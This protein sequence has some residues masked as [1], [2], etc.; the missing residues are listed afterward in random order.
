MLTLSTASNL[1][2]G[3]DTGSLHNVWKIITKLIYSTL[4]LYGKTKIQFCR[5]CIIMV[6]IPTTQETEANLWKLK[7]KRANDPQFIDV[8][9]RPMDGDPWNSQR[10]KE[11]SSIQVNVEQNIS[12]GLICS[13]TKQII[14]YIISEMIPCYLCKFEISKLTEVLLLNKDQ[15]AKQWQCQLCGIA[16]QLPCGRFYPKT[17]FKTLA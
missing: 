10:K 4:I 15:S 13:L 16:Y 2:L 8:D 9:L 17:T 5:P 11:V 1:K 3:S 7:L 14:V 6:L 12:L